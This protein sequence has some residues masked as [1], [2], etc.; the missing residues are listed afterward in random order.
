MDAE[1]LK[2]H[3]QL[4][5]YVIGCHLDGMDKRTFG[6]FMEMAVAA[7]SIFL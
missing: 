4:K 2:N 6:L 1:S 7:K 3:E 5:K